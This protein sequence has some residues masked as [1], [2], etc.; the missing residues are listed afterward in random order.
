MLFRATSIPGVM[1]LEPERAEDDR[2]WFARAWC[3]RELAEHGLTGEL[4]QA[5]LSHNKRKGTL[6]GMHYQIAPHE[7]AKVVRVVR[8]AAYDVALD[9][10]AGSP[11]FRRWVSAELS[12]DNGAAL[13][14][15]EGVAHGFQ[16]LADDTVLL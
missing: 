6:R 9:V 7:E 1:L 4:A 16:T 15:P 11:S 5:S 3:S 10:R 14:I 2:G 13:Y 12:E 8:G